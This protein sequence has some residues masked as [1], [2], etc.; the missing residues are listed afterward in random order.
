MTILDE[1]ISS[2]MLRKLMLELG[3]NFYDPNVKNLLLAYLSKNPILIWGPPGVGKTSTIEALAKKLR[4]PYWQPTVVSR[5]DMIMPRLNPDKD[6]IEMVLL[7]V[8]RKIALSEKGIV[9]LDE[10]NVILNDDTQFPILRF[11][12]SGVVGEHRI[13]EGIWRVGIANP[14]QFTLNSRPLSAAIATRLTHLDWDTGP[15]FVNAWC[16]NFPYYWGSPPK[17]PGIDEEKWAIARSIVSAF[18]R[19]NTNMLLAIPNDPALLSRPWPNP[20]TW[21]MASRYLSLV[22]QNQ[23]SLMDV[24]GHI[25]GVVGKSAFNAFLNWLGNDRIPD[26]DDVLHDV[27]RI[28][29]PDR[30]DKLYAI[31]TSCSTR[32]VSILKGGSDSERRWAWNAMWGLVR[33]FK[34]KN[35]LDIAVI[36]LAPVVRA[37]Q[38]NGLEHELPFPGEIRDFIEIASLSGVLEVF[39]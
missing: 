6:A 5:E 26:P 18:I 23:C 38:E 13:P 19:A 36:G 28:P 12:D 22:L 3:Y 10:L 4:I 11:L 24:K 32:V 17:L 30:K 33:R 9:V 29:L 31:I 25:S 2:E 15:T 34:N 8:F 14:P 16:M 35:A 37:R 20:R 1:P 7:D 27:E 39:R 21:T